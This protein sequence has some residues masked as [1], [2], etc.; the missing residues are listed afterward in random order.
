MISN[1]K[2]NIMAKDLVQKNLLSCSK[3]TTIY[4]AAMK[5]R[6]KNTS[7]I[8]IEDNE[9]VIGIW[10]EADSKKLNFS[11][12]NYYDSPIY[13]FMSAP[14]ITINEQ[15][16]LQEIIMTFHRHRVR[17]LLVVNSEKLT[18]GIVSQSDVIK[19]QGVEHYLRLRKIKDNYNPKVPII[20]GNLPISAVANAM[21]EYNC[22]SALIRHHQT[23]QFGIITERDL[24]RLVADKYNNSDAWSSSVYPLITINEE[25][26]LYQAYLCLQEHKIRHLVVEN[27][28]KEVAG[29]LSL[30]HILSDLEI[31]Y[32]QKLESVLVERDNALEQSK[33]NLVFA[34]KIIESSLDSIMVTNGKSIIL[35][36]NAAFTRL[37]GYTQEDV[38]GKSSNILSSG[39]HD[40][41][42]YQKMW[43]S[44]LEDKTW[45]GEI[46]N[47]K[48]CGTL[49]PEWLTIVQIND[50]NTPEP[51]Y[52]AIF[53]DITQRKLA[54]KRIHALAFYDELTGLP[55]RR[56]FNDRFEIALSTAH[57]NQQLVAVLFLDLDRFK[58]INDSLGHNIG[59]EILIA[60]AKRIQSSIKEGDTVSRFG[61]DEFVI[62]LT[63]MTSLKDIVGVIE[64]ITNVLNEPHQL[65]TLELQI[66]SSIGASVYPEDG[67]DS[68]TLL[69]HADTAMY[70]AKDEG[71]NSYQLYSPEMNTISMER[72]ITQNFLRS[73]LKKNEFELYYQLQVNSVTQKVVGI[74]ALLR[75]NHPDLGRVSPA[76]FIP[77][78][79]ELGLIVEIDKWVLTQACQ[80]RKIWQQQNFDCGRI[81]INIS[82]QHFKHNLIDSIDLALQKSGLSPALL[83]IEVT[84]NCFIENIKHASSTLQKI[85]QLGIKNSIDDFGTGFSSLSYLT[86]LPFDTLK[87]DASFIS[88]LPNDLKQCQIIKSII[89]MAK[90]LDLTL[91]GEGVETAEQANFLKVNGCD[92]I[93][94]YL[95]SIPENAEAVTERLTERQLISSN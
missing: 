39:K 68:D 11:D 16:P 95:Y 76:H 36:V 46:W 26:T 43:Q 92:V 67:L 90:G 27:S 32:F 73:A 59:D 83:E 75:W 10:T 5:I 15:M 86:Q 3:M 66:T 4:Q 6:E 94:G 25:D 33:R 47:K 2:K 40:K 91:V 72:L 14:V 22:T 31:A 82:S 74:E 51:L 63:E 12:I 77:M 20:L 87:I 18:L 84:E 41:A 34:E 53:S 13:K 89:A 80:Q 30:Q 9:K 85:R 7:S 70:K 28:Q 60:T 19:K 44:L 78:A 64:R 55:N 21:S 38:I 42:F 81:A 62:L 54:E 88:K 52:A 8:L 93:Q 37:T 69:K 24:L 29:V 49:Y 79:E 1:S 50:G 35:S 61:G 58:Q 23:N 45:Q 17:H 57:R 65:D 56:L 48:K 71:R